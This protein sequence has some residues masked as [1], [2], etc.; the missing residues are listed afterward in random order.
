MPPLPLQDAVHRIRHTRPQVP[1]LQPEH[2][3][4]PRI[5]EPIHIPRQIIR[6]AL[7]VRQPPRQRRVRRAHDVDEALVGEVARDDVEALPAGGGRGQGADVGEG[8]VADVD[9]GE[10][11]DRRRD[12]RRVAPGAEG[13]VAEALVG[14]VDGGAGGEPALD[15]AEG[16]G[17][18]DGGQVEARALVGDEGPGGFLGQDLSSGW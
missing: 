17:V 4:R 5:I 13:E 15:G 9:P 14:G 8:D 18:V 2:L 12:A 7:L 16:V 10:D 11:G 6:A 3:P 1:V